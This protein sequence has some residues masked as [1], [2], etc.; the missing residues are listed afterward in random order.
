MFAF[1]QSYANTN[2]GDIKTSDSQ[3]ETNSQNENLEIFQCS[4]SSSGTARLSDGTTVEL[5][6]TVTG[7]CNSSLA[8]KMRSAIAQARSD[9]AEM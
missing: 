5:T 3:T 9:M 4:V 7:P 8:G 1:A 2:D 6:I